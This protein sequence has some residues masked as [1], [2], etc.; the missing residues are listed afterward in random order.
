[1]KVWAS[2]IANPVSARCLIPAFASAC[3]TPGVNAGLASPPTRRDGHWLRKQTKRNDPI[4][5]LARDAAQDRT[6]PLDTSS[7][8]KLRSYIRSCC[9]CNGTVAA[10]EKALTEWLTT[11][12]LR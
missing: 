1:M 10:L 4:G 7:G 3:I 5:E 2:R 11:K 12:K 6:F 8:P 9:V